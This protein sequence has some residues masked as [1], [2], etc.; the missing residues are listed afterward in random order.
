MDGI[1]IGT[2]VVEASFGAIPKLKMIK[3]S[4]ARFCRRFLLINIKTIFFK[5][6]YQSCAEEC[7]GNKLAN[8][9]GKC[10]DWQCGIGH[11]KAIN[12]YKGNDNCIGNNGWQGYK[13]TV[14]S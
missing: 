6:E 7:G 8:S 10:Y 2:I 13:P 14:L 5:D 1:P 3:K 12:N 9:N 4:P 11:T